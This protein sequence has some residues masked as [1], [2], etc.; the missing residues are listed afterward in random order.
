[1]SNAATSAFPFSGFPSSN[2]EAGISEPH[3]IRDRLLV[4]SVAVGD[5]DVVTVTFAEICDN[6]TLVFTPSIGGDQVS[7]DCRGG[8]VPSKYRPPR[9]R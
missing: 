4:Q 5:K 1:M 9:C 2:K 3:E 8:T 6:H 7:W